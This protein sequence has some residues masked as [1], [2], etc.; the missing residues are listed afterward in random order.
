MYG[1][2]LLLYSGER[3]NGD[4]ATPNPNRSG[5]T[6]RTAAVKTGEGLELETCKFC[7]FLILHPIILVNCIIT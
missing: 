7:L 6:E 4:E 2:F 1:C 5:Q 3:P